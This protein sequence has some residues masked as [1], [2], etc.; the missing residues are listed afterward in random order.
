MG[1]PRLKIKNELRYRPGPTSGGCSDCDHYVARFQVRKTDATPLA[2]EPRCRLI[3]MG[4]SRRYRIN[5][6]HICDHF[7]NFT[8]LARLKGR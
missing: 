3:G 8:S 2:I 6:G 4:N 1:V 5:P 7:D